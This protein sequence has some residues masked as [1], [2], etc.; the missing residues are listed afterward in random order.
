M[1]S[2]PE[3]NAM[4]HAIHSD[5][6]TRRFGKVPAV[7]DLDLRVPEGSITAFLGPNGAGKTTTIRLLLG[8]LKPTSGSCEVLGF[9]PGH[10]EALRQ[11]GAMVESPSLYGHLTGHEN[12]EITR[13]MRGAP[14]T[15]TERVLQVVGLAADARRLVQQYSLG[16]R[17]RLGLALALIGSPRLL[18]MDEPTNG[19]DPSGIQ[20]MREL[21]RHV[22]ATIGAT[23][24]L[25]SHILAEVEQVASQVVVIHRGRLR[26]QGP[27]EDL[28][29]RG[30]ALLQL[31]VDDPT[32]AGALLRAR[33]LTVTEEAP[34]LLVQATENE[35]PTVAAC[36]VGAGLALYELAPRRKNL[37]ARFLELLEDA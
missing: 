16:M 21:I 25:S 37:E 6:L 14:R 36:L 34:Y 3:E 29:S 32:R 4:N 10:P 31:R 9:R 13:L 35:A 1:F 26:Y 19:L 17:Q 5:A 30:P 8:L 15:E 23:V 12:V 11:L 22:P 33:N 27:T 18:V 20:E 28:G 7:E 24:F 2:V